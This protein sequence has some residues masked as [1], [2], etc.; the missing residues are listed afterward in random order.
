MERV[1][2]AADVL[3]QMKLNLYCLTMRTPR[4]IDT[5]ARR[6]RDA[7]TPVDIIVVDYLQLLQASDP[8]RRK[9]IY[10]NVSTVSWELKMIANDMK[11]PLLVL[12]QLNRQ[13]EQRT[14]K[15][16]IPADLRDSGSLEQDATAVMFL[17]RDE[18]YNPDSADVGIGEINVSLNRNGK[19]GV[20]KFVLDFD[21]M[22]IFNCK[23]Q[24]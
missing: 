4:D 12:S 15:R 2:Q 21:H 9:Y 16:P 8:G 3:R 10:D 6:L 19:T 7:G 14:N 23:E 20:S 17:Y 22:S 13:L 5:E 24:L 1:T 11:V 18:A